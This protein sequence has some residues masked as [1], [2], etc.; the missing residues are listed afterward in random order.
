MTTSPAFLHPLHSFEGG[1]STS[2][3]PIPT[4]PSETAGES[5]D[6]PQLQSS[7]LRIEESHSH[8]E[9]VEEEALLSNVDYNDDNMPDRPPMLRPT[10][11]RSALPLLKDER[12]RSSYDSPA[13]STRPPFVARRS[14]FRNRSPAFE[15]GS[16]AR[17]RYIYAGIALVVS[18]VSFVIQTITASYIQ[19]EL[20]WHKAYCML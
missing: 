7:S 18:L 9:E 15:A 2:S 5:Y 17:Q 19:Q 10:D 6:L 1:S 8:G 11:E 14:T 4:P 3:I 13:G 12:G 16:D 20:K